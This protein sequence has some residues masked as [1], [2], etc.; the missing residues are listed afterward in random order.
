MSK[1][2]FLLCIELI[3]RGKN[4]IK[5]CLKCDITSRVAKQSYYVS[6]HMSFRCG[7]EK[8]EVKLPIFSDY[9][10]VYVENL[11]EKSIILVT[12]MNLAKLQ[13]S[14]LVYTQK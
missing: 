13:D 8:K 12:N 10:V 1:Y 3:L 9:M 11:K 6:V 2:H 14:Y 5:G 4:L 7:C